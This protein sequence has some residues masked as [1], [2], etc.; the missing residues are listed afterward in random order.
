MSEPTP[1]TAIHAPAGAKILVVDD[2][3]SIAD[4]LCEILRKAGYECK[5]AYSAM[6]ALD[7]LDEFGPRLIISDVMMPDM[8]G[9]EMAKTIRGE[10]PECTVVLFSGNAA[11]H[12]LLVNSR[13]EGYYFD[14]LAKPMPPRDLVAKVAA[15]I[16]NL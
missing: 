2:E 6:D 3:R 13:A 7:A 11:T 1:V 10:H 9:I 8:N 14:V 4:T 16:S 5:P 12:D 15:L